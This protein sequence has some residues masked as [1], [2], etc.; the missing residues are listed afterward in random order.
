[1]CRRT[2]AYAV[3]CCLL[4]LAACR[5]APDRSAGPQP[6]RKVYNDKTGRLER[7]DYDTRNSG[8]IDTRCYMDGTRILRIEVDR[9]GD[10]KVDRW[11]YYGANDTLEKVGVSRRNDGIPDA[12]AYEGPDG[13]LARLEISTAHDGKVSRTEYYEHGVLVRSEEDTAG[14]GRP[15]KWETFKNGA[16]QSV[17]FDTTHRGTPDLRLTYLPDGRVT[18]E[19]LK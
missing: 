15:N 5:Q 8:R 16:L 7:L 12:W 18:T 6:A 4:C 3:T 2:L 14:S 17:A 1:M 10:G 13:S 9:D 11:E 19:K